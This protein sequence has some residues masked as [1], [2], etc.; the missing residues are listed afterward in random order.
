MP[1]SR[2]AFGSARRSPA[3]RPT[4]RAVKGLSLDG[5]LRPLP[6][7]ERA[8]RWEVRGLGERPRGPQAVSGRLGS[9]AE[10]L[11]PSRDTGGP[12]PGCGITRRPRRT[13]GRLCRSDSPDLGVRYR[14]PGGRD[15]EANRTPSRPAVLRGP[16][17]GVGSS[18]CR[19]CPW[20][21]RERGPAGQARGTNDH[22]SRTRPRV[23][24]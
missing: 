22:R 19:R 13:I 23:P 15:G 6:W 18:S 24:T 3:R 7:G 16:G 10:L 1:T 9:R 20:H 21:G 8:E 4:K 17:G 12:P 11:G 14:L 2:G 5:V